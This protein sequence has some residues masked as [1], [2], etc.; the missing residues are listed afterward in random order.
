MLA[1]MSGRYHFSWLGRPLPLTAY[2]LQV[3]GCRARIEM[4]K[5]SGEATLDLESP[6]NLAAI[7]RGLIA[8][9]IGW[10]IGG[11]LLLGAAL[12]LAGQGFLSER[13][14]SNGDGSL[15]IKYFD[16]E[17]YG[18]P[19]ELRLGWQ[20]QGDHGAAVPLA[21][22][23]TFVDRTI[24]RAF[25]PPPESAVARGDEIIYRFA[26]P[27]S[28]VHGTIVMRYQHQTFGRVPCQ[29]RLADR[30]PITISQLVLP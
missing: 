2:R 25:V 12:G 24:D 7:R 3:H 13:T 19:T 16:I 4:M 22:S 28:E 10:C 26:C 27:R 15:R 14:A 21:F 30:P 18:T 8:D 9:R 6:D 5:S 29:I 17:R 20:M 11:A 23:R 1:A